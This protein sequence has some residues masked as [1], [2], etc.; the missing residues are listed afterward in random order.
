MYKLY[1]YPT[2]AFGMIVK[3]SSTPLAKVVALQA[4]K[5]LFWAAEQSPKLRSDAVSLLN[6]DEICFDLSWMAFHEAE[7]QHSGGSVDRFVEENSS[8]QDLNFDSNS[9]DSFGSS[10]EPCSRDAYRAVFPNNWP[11]YGYNYEADGIL[12]AIL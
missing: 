12:G 10:V 4:R 7:A 5:L 1:P 2:P 3:K 8:A 6:L 11:R 9:R